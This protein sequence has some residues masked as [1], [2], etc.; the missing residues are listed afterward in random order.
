MAGGAGLTMPAGLITDRDDLATEDIWPRL[1]TDAGQARVI[2]TGGTEMSFAG[3]TR[4]FAAGRSDPG[5][6]LALAL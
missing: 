5:P 6:G 3:L 1:Q 4:A 2:V